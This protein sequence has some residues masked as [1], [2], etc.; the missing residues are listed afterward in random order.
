MPG[1][2]AARV[3]FGLLTG[4][5]TLSAQAV[6]RAPA[7]P[8]AL[9]T[10][11]ALEG[12]FGK[13]AKSVWPGVVT[14]RALARRPSG[15]AAP[16]PDAKVDT[17]PMSGWMAALD[18]AYPGFD[19]VSAGSGF[20]CDS[21]GDVLTCH[22]VVQKP[23]GSPADL[24]E[25]QLNDGLR[26]LAE[27]VGAEPTVNL[28]ILHPVVFLAGQS[29]E[30]TFLKFGDSEVLETGQYTF[31][32]GNPDGPEKF[33]TPGSFVTRPSRDCYQD[34]L[35]AFYMQLAMVAHPQAYGGPVVNL[36][37][38]V[39]GVLGPRRPVPGGSLTDPKLG[40]E[41]AMPSKIVTG[42]YEAIRAARS[43]QSPW[44]GFAVMS[45]AEIATVRGI[46]AYQ[47]MD[48]PRAGILI[49][50]VFRPSPAAAAGLEPGDF[51]V[52]FDTTQIF[53][54]VD[55]QKCLYLAGIGAQ[56]TLEVYRKG[57]TKTVQLKIEKRPPEATPR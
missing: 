48:K 32:F 20:F 36:A 13:L 52:K 22:H 7:A 5:A 38:E 51:L 34:Q 54:P 47:A 6:L 44:L 40:L 55:F 19:V 23:D 26:V 14:V 42:L 18:E 8:P 29:S 11:T 25:L 56:V 9:P 24:I 37:G 12:E 41:M 1:M 16:T 3:L 31:A 53:N 10:A 43:F 33:F 4:A 45:R 39:V 28:A 21:S 27:L 49:E 17:G 50:N 46:E 35:S 2:H 30:A 15:A 57:E